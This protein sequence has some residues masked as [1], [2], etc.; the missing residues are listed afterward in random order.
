MLAHFLVFFL[1]LVIPQP[2]DT[3]GGPIAS[4][5]TNNVPG[6]SATCDRS[7]HSMPESPIA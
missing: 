2:I 5:A 3:P 1:S 7:H 6:V 4:Y